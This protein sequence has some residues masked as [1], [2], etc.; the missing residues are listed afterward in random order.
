[1]RAGRAARERAARERAAPNGA[2][3]A[4]PGAESR[5]ISAR[6]ENCRENA[7]AARAWPPLDILSGDEPIEP[8]IASAAFPWTANLAIVYGICLKRI[9]MKPE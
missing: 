2:L 8:Y 3:R 5:R 6:S 9:G 1:M 4:A 7:G